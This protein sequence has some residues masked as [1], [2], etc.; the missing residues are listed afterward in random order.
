MLALWE[1]AGWVYW[2]LSRA[3]DVG[4]Q[5]HISERGSPGLAAGVWGVLQ[6]GGL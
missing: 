4:C 6:R 1:M 3:W 2:D 5:V